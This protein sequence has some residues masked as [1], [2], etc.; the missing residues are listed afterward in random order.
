MVIFLS[1]AVEKTLFLFFSLATGFFSKS[2]IFNLRVLLID[3][4]LHNSIMQFLFVK[5]LLF[6]P[7]IELNQ[8]NTLPRLKFTV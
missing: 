4:C 6:Q 1:N 3:Y 5:K 8:C 7:L 2:I